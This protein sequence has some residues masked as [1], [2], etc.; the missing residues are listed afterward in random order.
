MAEKPKWIP[1]SKGKTDD[2][3][4][5]RDFQDAQSLAEAD[6]TVQPGSLIDEMRK[7]SSQTQAKELSATRDMT[8]SV[9][10]DS[11]SMTRSASGVNKDVGTK[12]KSNIPNMSR[13]RIT[14]QRIQSYWR[15]DRMTKV[16]TP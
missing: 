11:G 13:L 5:E 2:T 10:E 1:M 6:T 9:S 14:L 4:D 7:A 12:P 15:K 16:P 8:R 3:K